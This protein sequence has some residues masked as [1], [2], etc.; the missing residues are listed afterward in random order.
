MPVLNFDDNGVIGNELMKISNTLAAGPQRQL[1]AAHIAEEIRKSAEARARAQEEWDAR[2]SAAEFQPNMDRLVDAKRAAGANWTPEQEEQLLNARRRFGQA[3][4]M[5]GALGGEPVVKGLFYGQG[6]TEMLAGRPAPGT[7]DYTQVY[8]ATAGKPPD[9]TKEAK[10]PFTVVF[11]DPSTGRQIP[12]LTHDGVNDVY[13]GKPI[14]SLV[15]SNYRPQGIGSTVNV[16][17]P[18]FGSPEKN[19]NDL[20]I[21]NQE[22]LQGRTPAEPL[23][24]L[25]QKYYAANP[26]IHQ[27]GKDPFG[28]NIVIGFNKEED[29]PGLQAVN[30]LL[31]R[32]YYGKGQ[33]SK[34]AETQTG[35]PT[36]PLPGAGG[37]PAQPGGNVLPGTDQG[38][39]SGAPS[40][41][42][43]S[44]PAT[45][46]P[47][48]RLAAPGGAAAQPAAPGAPPAAAAGQPYKWKPSDPGPIKQQQTAPGSPMSIT[49]VNRGFD[50]QEATNFSKSKTVDDWRTTETA[51]NGMQRA[52]KYD[53]GYGDLHMIYAL[54]KILDP[55]SAVREGELDLAKGAGSPALRLKGLFSY[56]KGGGRLTPEQRQQMLE[57][58][59]T[60]ATSSFEAT[61][62]LAQQ[63]NDTL[64]QRDLDPRQH[65]PELTQPPRF[66]NKEINRY[67]NGIF[68]GKTGDTPGDAELIRIGGHLNGGA[69]GQTSTSA[70]GAP[71]D[72]APSGTRRGAAAVQ[73]TPT[74]SQAAPS[75]TPTAPPAGISAAPAKKP[76]DDDALFNRADALVGRRR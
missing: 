24:S 7:A 8:T 61:V 23:A 19:A 17:Q 57:Q 28:G 21:A 43:T 58:A 47:T 14:S 1:Q 20:Q 4:T 62:N 32:E 3:S 38:L 12:F 36:A 59:Y 64:L 31:R 70:A 68:D 41:R 40:V 74:T 73:A 10:A 11:A 51:Y 5:A 65:L 46:V 50:Q 56:V 25:A 63:T 45:D 16:T 76:T 18:G 72:I 67:G 29:N 55:G 69:P 34:P 52:A 44:V 53:N 66:D 6:Q 48:N 39:L 22:I 26:K 75:P 60:K 13:T 27:P 37:A 49:Q 15:P 54:A 42:T 9:P 30:A 71:P 35:I 33:T 2:R